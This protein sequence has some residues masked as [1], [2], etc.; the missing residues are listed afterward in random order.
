LIVRLICPVCICRS[1]ILL[2]SKNNIVEHHT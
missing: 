1:L 2:K